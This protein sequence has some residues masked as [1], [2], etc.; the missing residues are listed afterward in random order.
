MNDNIALEMAKPASGR[1]VLPMVEFYCPVCRLGDCGSQA[2]P[3]I[4]AKWFDNLIP[5]TKF[6]TSQGVRVKVAVEPRQ[7]AVEGQKRFDAA[8]AQLV[9]FQ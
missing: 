7:P 1:N 2:C 5:L 6:A 3:L 4:Q 9:L 8:P